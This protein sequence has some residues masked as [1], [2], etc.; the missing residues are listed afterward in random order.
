MTENERPVKFSKCTPMRRRYVRRKKKSLA[1][2]ILFRSVVTKLLILPT[3]LVFFKG[4]SAGEAVGAFGSDGTVVG[5]GILFFPFC[6]VAVAVAVI[7]AVESDSAPEVE[8]PSTSL[9]STIVTLLSRTCCES[10]LSSFI[11]SAVKRTRKLCS[12]TSSVRMA[13]VCMS[14]RAEKKMYASQNTVKVT[15][16]RKR[17]RTQNQG[18]MLLLLGPFSKYL[19]L[20]K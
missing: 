18:R 19:M 10:D 17:Q 8:D 5:L 14:A 2:I 6:T 4:F 20:C 7:V 1:R 13:S 15:E 16:L 9:S 11:G 12:N 3:R